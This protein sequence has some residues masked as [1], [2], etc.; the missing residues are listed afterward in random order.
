VTVTQRNK[1]DIAYG[2]FLAPA[3][4]SLIA[5][6]ASAIPMDSGTAGGIGF[7]VLIPLAIVALVAVP[8]GVFYSVVF[9]RDGVLPLLSILTILMVA[10]AVTEAGSVEFYNATGLVYGILVLVLEASWFLLR[11]RRAYPA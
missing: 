5:A 11:R 2:C 6:V 3:A 9:W 8:I 1:H 10:E 4:V 7:L